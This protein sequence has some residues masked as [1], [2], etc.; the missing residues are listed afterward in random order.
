VCEVDP[1]TVL[2]WLVEVAEQLQAFTRYCLC[3]VHIKQL[4]LDELYAVLRGVKDGEISE[5]NALKRLEPAHLWVWTAIDPVSK[6]LLVLEVGP[7]TVAMAQRVVHQVVGVLAPGCAPA[8]LSDGFK[9]YLPAIVGHFGWWVHPERRQDKGPWPKPRWMPLP[10]LLY[11][12][13]IK[14]YRRK[15]MVGVKHRVVFGTMDAIEQVLSVCGSSA[16]NRGA[17]H[18]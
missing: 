12:Q 7:R 6:L 13:V 1:S 17:A 3:D 16:L 10:G 5:A 18:L 11:A 9:G 4:Q 8:W 15:R 14:Q 2:Q